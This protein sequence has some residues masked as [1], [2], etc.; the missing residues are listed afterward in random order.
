[1]MIS[2]VW[3]ASRRY[4]SHC[5]CYFESSA[6]RGW[7]WGGVGK[8]GGGGGGHIAHGTKVDAKHLMEQHRKDFISVLGILSGHPSVS[9]CLGATTRLVLYPVG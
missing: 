3:Q 7:G 5:S 6:Y 1:M 4:G 8:G 2:L 9:V